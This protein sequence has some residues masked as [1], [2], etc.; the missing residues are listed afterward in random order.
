MILKLIFSTLIFTSAIE[1]N[2]SARHQGLLSS[3]NVGARYSSILEKRG[4]ILYRDFQI[5]PVVGVFFFDDR[6]E[7][8]GDSLGY[9]DFIFEDKIRFRSRLVSITD[10][11]L[12]P[13]TASVQNGSPSRTDTYEWSNG[14]EFFF[15]GYND[16]YQAEIDLTYSKD[17]GQHHGNYFELQSKTKLFSLSLEKWQLQ[18]EPNFVFTVGVGDR[19]HNQYFYGPNDEAL[20]INNISYGFWVA[21]PKEADRAFPILQLTRFSVIGDHRTAAYADQRNEGFLLSFLA[22]YGFLD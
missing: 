17:V 10:K 21:F 8:L 12:F 14:L 9:H 16:N 18:L 2:A 13:A 6:L 7:F 1:A 5:D 15:P 19:A 20:G 4:V 11:P 22:T 3:I